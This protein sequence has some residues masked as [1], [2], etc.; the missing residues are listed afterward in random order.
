M[1]GTAGGKEL[2][3]WSESSFAVRKYC[4]FRSSDVNQEQ[5]ICKECCRVV[6]APQNHTGNL[7]SHLKT[8]HKLQAGQENH[9]S[10]RTSIKVSNDAV[11]SPTQSHLGKD[12]RV[13]QTRSITIAP[14]K[15]LTYN[16]FS[17]VEIP[18]PYVKHYW[19]N[20]Q[21]SHSCQAL[22]Y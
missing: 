8:K 5:I 2:F 7:F 17:K 21:R 18:V 6:S 10:A 15:G 1:R 11:K 19:G 22:C 20:K 3:P 16:Y 13:N 4:K 9:S 14:G 12:A